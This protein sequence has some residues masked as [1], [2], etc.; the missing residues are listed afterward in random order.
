MVS[1]SAGEKKTE[2]NRVMVR[3]F[4]GEP[5]ALV[6]VAVRP[7]SVEVANPADREKTI[8]F[9]PDAVYRFDEKLFGQLKAAH[10]RRDGSKLAAL[11]GRAVLYS[12]TDA[13]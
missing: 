3:A 10:D 12:P 5:V 6:A 4:G 7:G 11:W 1:T 8:G 2:A 13:E 9:S